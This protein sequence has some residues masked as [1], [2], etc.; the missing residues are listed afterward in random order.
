VPGQSAP[1]TLTVANT[2][3]Y[4]VLLTNLTS[5]S[6]VSSDTSACASSNVTVPSPGSGYS[7][8]VPAGSTGTALSL[9][10]FVTMVAAAQDGCQGKAFTVTLAFSGAQTT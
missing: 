6:V 1:L 10:G 5:A 3:A 4:P 2:N 9:P 8:R 7:L